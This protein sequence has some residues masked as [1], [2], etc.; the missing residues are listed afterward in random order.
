MFGQPEV[1]LAGRTTVID[2]WL[3]D[4]QRLLVTQDIPDATT[5]RLEVK[6]VDVRTKVEQRY[7]ERATSN[8][9]VWLPAEQAV[10]FAEVQ[11]G[12][13]VVLGVGR[14]P[15]TP[16]DVIAT[17]LANPFVSARPDGQEV[18]A[19]A[20]RDPGQPQTVQTGRGPQR[21]RRALG[22]VFRH[23][24]QQA[25]ELDGDRVLRTAW[26]PDGKQLIAFNAQGFYLV[27]VA[28]GRSCAVDLGSTAE[29]TRWA[30]DV[31]WSPDSRLVAA[32]TT[33]SAGAG[34][35]PF[36]NLT[37]LDTLTGELQQIMLDL[38]F[39]DEAEWLPTSRQMVAMANV[40]LDDPSTGVRQGL[41]VV[42]VVSGAFRR[43]V[44][45]L[46]FGFGLYANEGGGLAVSPDG[47]LAAI[48]CPLWP[49]ERTAIIEDRVCTVPIELQP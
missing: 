47:R 18:A 1:V 22:P 13:Q 37:I 44:P 7:A 21:G 5:Q 16:T 46:T 20:A 34:S 2:G 36:L 48:K 38:P 27:D 12:R 6:T 9:A 40:N 26:S 45:E 30:R 39:V 31:R 35:V 49:I 11:P 8:R 24:Q 32:R 4:S 29:G 33:I 42:D 10:A 28:S 43:V 23:G 15:A 3:P 17:D 19:F 25:V 14:G 41:F